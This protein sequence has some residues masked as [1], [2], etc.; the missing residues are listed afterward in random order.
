MSSSNKLNKRRKSQ[1]RKRPIGFQYDT[2][3]TRQVLTTVLPAFSPDATVLYQIHGASDQQGQLSEIDL[4]NETF[5]DVGSNAGFKI[6]GTGFRTAD[7]YIYGI[8]MDADQLIRIGA[9]GQNEILGDIDGLP[10]GNYFTGDFGQ[11]GLLYLRHGNN[12]YGVN[13]DTVAVERVATADQNVSKTYDITYNPETGLHYSVRKSGTRAEFISIDL[14]S[15]SDVATVSV[16]N[17]NL[18]PAGTYGALFSDASGRVFAANN[19]GGLYEIELETGVATYAGHSPSA[20]SNDG[21]ASSLA[22]FDLPPVVIDAWM[23]T[24]VGEAAANIPIESPYDLEGQTLQINVLELPDVGQIFDAVGNA[25][26]VNQSLTVEDLIGLK[27]QPPEQVDSGVGPVSFVYEVSDGLHISNGSV[28]ISLA[29]LSR[30]T[31]QVIVHDDTEESSFAGYVYNN[32]IRITG[33][34]YLGTAIDQTVLTD[35]NGKYEFTDVAPGTYQIEQLQ[36]P[37]VFDGYVEFGDADSIVKSNAIEGLV[38]SSDPNLINGP[39][40]F[41]YAPT[42]ISGFSYVDSNANG[43]VDV[44]DPGIGS[45]AIELSGTDFDG[46]SISRFTTTNS[47]GYY[48]FRGLAPG[49]YRVVQTQPDQFISAQSNV[50]EFGGIASNNQID[51]IEL[52]AG[53]LGNGYSFGEYENSSLAGNVFVDNDIDKAFDS[54]DTPLANVTLRLTGVDFQG[55]QIQLESTTDALGAYLFDGLAAGT[56][57]LTQIQPLELDDGFSHIGIFNNDETTLASNGTTGVNQ[58]ADIT[59]GSGRHGR[60]FNFSERISYRFATSFDQTLT[61]EGTD[62]ADHFEFVAGEVFHTVTLNGEEFLIDAAVNSNILFDGKLGEDHVSLTGSTKIE[63][64]VTTGSTATMR[65]ENWRI[66]TFASERFVANSGGGYDR[67]FMYD[68]VEDDRVKMQQDYS[69]LWND[70][71]SAE[72]HGYHRSYAYAENGGED[73]AYL[74]DSKY[75]DTVKM[76]STSAR[77]IS[78]N[79]Y[80][81]AGNFERV[82]A[83]AVNG[84][85][86]R[87]QFWDSKMDNDVFQASPEYARM[88]NK[89]FYNI[90]TGFKQI[91][92]F[93][94]NGG[95][96]DRAYLSGSEG[97][98]LLIGTPEKTGMTGHGFDFDVHDF[99]RTY[100]VSNGGNDR[101]LLFDSKLDDRFVARPDQV[102]LYNDDYY[103]SAKGFGD[104]DAF[105]SSG[106]ND[107]AYFY[108]SAGDD[109][110]VT[111]E[112]EMRLFGT[113]FDNTSH[114][115]ARNYAHSTKGGHDAALLYDTA[116]AD[117]V[118]IG[119]SVSKMYG[120]SYYSWLN[121]FENVA[122]RFTNAS[123]YDRA[124]AFGTVDSD[125]LAMSGELAD[126]IYDHAADFIYDTDAHELDD[127]DDDDMASINDD[128]AS[129]ASNE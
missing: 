55:N 68:T 83:Y 44:D 101:A 126:L 17:D 27:Y 122:T 93:A 16:I 25:V 46:N 125:T 62:S 77:M 79:F 54:G 89:S 81:F 50:G 120:E 38:V 75:D 41:E 103:L 86:D 6:N 104:V 56:Y 112:N 20:S 9:D 114:G 98:D 10:N 14:T 42:L 117:T 13:V 118:K 61:F 45:V 102:R 72:T 90:A 37:V 28:E 29:G 35:V 64:V 129:L 12:F 82:Y 23:S 59:V 53:Q 19:A 32:E 8:K 21:A 78:R 76:T 57:S 3:E 113:G 88:Y 95:S 105:S 73:R 96:N 100:A 24:T 94:V 18:Q 58:I 91:D 11:D 31:G 51:G 110:L 5:A 47:Y 108:D 39:T 48:E 106:G 60:S 4:A 85:S 65:S 71:Y 1:K 128:L 30:I 115:F 87:A 40:F 2:L 26:S 66:H 121:G 43:V 33:E 34:N 15:A 99:E 36:P 127:E 74:Y 119:A 70:N 111:L 7:G 84:G 49:T 92:A 67:A 22:F 109:T 63:D 97:D 80:N 69:R 124:L 116:Q 123:R 107:R 52:S